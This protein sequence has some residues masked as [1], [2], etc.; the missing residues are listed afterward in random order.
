MSASPT[1]NMP[2]VSK[3]GLGEGEY[4]LVWFEEGWAVADCIC[5]LMNILLK[6]HQPISGVNKVQT[7]WVDGNMYITYVGEYNKIRDVYVRTWSRV[8]D[9]HTVEEYNDP[10]DGVQGRAIEVRTFTFA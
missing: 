2:T 7:K 1:N 10:V 4:V 3:T 8:F 6:D 5:T 9:G